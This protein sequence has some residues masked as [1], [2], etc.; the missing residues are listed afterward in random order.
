MECSLDLKIRDKQVCYLDHT[1][2]VHAALMQ[3][4]FL[5]RDEVDQLREVASTSEAHLGDSYSFSRILLYHPSWHHQS[6][7]SVAMQSTALH[8]GEHLGEA[9]GQHQ[10]SFQRSEHF[11]MQMLFLQKPWQR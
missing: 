5:F 4:R 8:Q 7:Y 10:N 9:K 6:H 1:Q 3:S 2:L 11:H